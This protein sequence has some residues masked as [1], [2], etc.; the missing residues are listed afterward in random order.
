M[1]VY[2][3]ITLVLLIVFVSACGY[4]SDLYLPKEKQTKAVPGKQ[5]DDQKQ[6]DDDTSS[7]QEQ[8]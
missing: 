7:K 3:F 8:N 5:T 6:K 1:S 4:K 2:R